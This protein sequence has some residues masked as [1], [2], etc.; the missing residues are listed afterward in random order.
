MTQKQILIIEDSPDLADS[1]EDM[2]QLK[3]Y[4]TQKATS[5]T[6]GLE[7]ALS[8]KPDL[9]LLDL[10]L[11]DMDGLTI[12]K[13]IRDDKTWGQTA[14]VLILTASDIS[15]ENNPELLKIIDQ[16]HILYK[17]YSSIHELSYRISKELKDKN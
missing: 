4:H 15:K 13:N 7:L 10:K 5:G 1:L 12:L 9:I 16:D 11:P 8:T 17:S 2:L 3:G 14:K 6:H